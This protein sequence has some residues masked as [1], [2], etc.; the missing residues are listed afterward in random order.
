MGGCRLEVAKRVEHCRLRPPLGSPLC[1][2]VC[3]CVFRFPSRVCVVG[4]WLDHVAQMKET[5]VR[6]KERQDGTRQAEVLSRGRR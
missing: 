2:C 6:L 3:V 4:S 5:Q 1:V